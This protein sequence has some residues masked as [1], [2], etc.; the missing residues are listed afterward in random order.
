MTLALVKNA[1]WGSDA[2]E[3]PRL[4]AEAPRPGFRI[5]FVTTEYVT[6]YGNGGGL[7]NYLSR[8]A[9]LLRDAGHVPE[10]FVLSERDETVHH[11]GIRVERVSKR[12]VDHLACRPRRILRRMGLRPRFAEQALPILG[13]A[14]SLAAAVRRRE[15]EAPF[16]MIQSADFQAAG[17]FVRRV[18]Q[19]PHV[20]RCSLG[21]ELWSETDGVARRM[22]W[23]RRLER[24]TVARADFAYAP[25]RFIADYFGSRFG[26]PVGVV[27]PPAALEVSAAAEP[28]IALPPRFFL[29]FGQMIARKGSAVLAEALPLVWERAPEF[30]MVWAGRGKADVVERWREEWG[31]RRDQVTWLGPL[32]KPVLYSVLQR[33][34]ASVLPSL[35]DNLPNTVIE[36]LLLDKPVIGS[37][38]ASIDEIVSDGENGL[39]V[40]I[41]DPQA[42]AD[43]IFRAWRGEMRWELPLISKS[44]I[45]EDL[46]PENAIRNLLS[47]RGIRG[48]Q[49]RV[50]TQVMTAGVAQ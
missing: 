47:L 24:W 29:H 50:E 10:I 33:A 8:L 15:A 4:S 34:E 2:P 6:E 28:G 36:S 49:G 41:G 32:E 25:S 20:V 18:R 14:W 40:P 21:A 42:L 17:L 45:Y 3:Q 44:P 12:R 31:A 30:R 26:I 13:G 5:G 35:V 43:A 7:G 16:D 23:T 38:G 27:R 22:R 48:E 1:I 46:Q 11:A 39:L 9:A 37:R 19:R